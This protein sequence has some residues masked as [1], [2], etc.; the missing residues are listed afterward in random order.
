MKRIGWRAGLMMLVLVGLA[1]F[2]LVWTKWGAPIKRWAG[3]GTKSD[4]SR[5]AEATS[6]YEAG[7]WKRAADVTRPL[8]K[9]KADNLEALRLYARA[10][11]RMKH[12]S[13][14]A[15]IYSRLGV[16]RLEP[17]DRFL[18]GMLQVRAGQP[19]AALE[20]WEETARAGDGNP[21]LLD[22][23]AKLSARMER[24][25][26]AADAARRLAAKPSWEAR[27]LLL[28]GEIQAMLDDPRGSVESLRAALERDPSAS[29]A[30]FPLADYRKRLARGLLKLGRP[31]EARAALDALRESDGAGGLD[32]E[33]EWLLSRAWLQEG[34]LE[35]AASA[36][37]SAGSYRSENPLDPEPSPYVGG[38]RCVSCHREVSRSHDLSRHARTFHH[39]RD[40]LD[41]P[42]PDRPLADPGDAKI[43]HA[44][45]RENDKIKVETRAGD[46]VYQLIVEYA[47]GTSD[48]YVT[49]VG[50]DE[51]RTYRAVRL[52]SYHTKDGMGWDR[53][54]GDVPDSDASE[55]KQGA[56]IRVRDGVVRCVY[57]HTTF[58]RE[59]RDP[60]PESIGPEAADRG[61]G[62]ERCHGPGGN[63]VKAIEGNFAESAIMNAGTGGANAIGRLCAG[64]HIVGSPTVISKT[65]ADPRWARSPGLTLNFSRCFSE[66]DGAMSCMTC[67]DAHRDDREPV[68]FYEAKCLGCHAAQA[69]PERKLVAAGPSIGSARAGKKPT[70]CPVNAT[71]KCLEC[72]M[73]KVPMPTLHRDLTDHY[74]RVRDP[75]GRK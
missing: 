51:A 38:A 73:P 46:Q 25:D 52:S 36:S 71:A 26:E 7:D 41:L 32:R 10:S 13:A 2:A 49:M 14:A 64:C 24:F 20:L 39:G 68:S 9:S 45:K 62:C 18:L 74:I 35:R 57:C 59:F 8:L 65:P 12:D 19:E 63:H 11:A 23:L 28:L 70:V 15:S 1:S 60:P 31:A 42:F 54:A 44:F 4:S 61:I 16:S 27:G 33:A 50:R 69:R 29:G 47:F 66:S 67:H 22:N 53:S 17:E 34:K 55:N 58:Y 30:P 48:R 21:E 6:A 56:P 72:H 75:G 37:S 3:E 40:L 43:T 5:L